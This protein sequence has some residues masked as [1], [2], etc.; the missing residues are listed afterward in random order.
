[1][2]D[3]EVDIYKSMIDSHQ[4]NIATLDVLKDLKSEYAS[5]VAAAVKAKDLK[6]RQAAR[7]AVIS[8]LAAL[9]TK[10]ET[11]LASYL[12]EVY[13]RTTS[14]VRR[15]FQQLSAS[16]KNLLVDYAINV[17]GGSTQTLEPT[18]DPLKKLYQAYFDGRLYEKEIEADR[19]AKA[20]K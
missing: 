5:L 6:A 10:E 15:S 16:E 8:R 1:M 11:E 9:K 20:R 4:A 13:E 19:Q 17:V 2:C 3:F 18:K 12:D 14:Y 7:D